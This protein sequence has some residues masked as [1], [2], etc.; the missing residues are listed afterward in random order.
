MVVQLALGTALI[1]V[2]ILLSALAFWV[3]EAILIRVRPWIA[4]T[5]HRPKLMLMLC[6]AVLWSFSTVVAGVW[7]WAV[8]FRL[9]D[10]FA[11]LEGAVYFSIVAYTTLGF[12]DILLPQEWRL[13]GGM[14]SANGLLNFGLLTAMLVEVL[15]YVRVEQIA[16][17]VE[18]QETS[19]HARTGFFFSD[20][21]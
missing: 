21:H 2:S 6:L 17:S 19:P 8:T 13:L 14:A 3:L 9:L 16:A 12:G 4:R 7:I 10:V 1:L 11:T 15:R 5:P 18:E 20:R